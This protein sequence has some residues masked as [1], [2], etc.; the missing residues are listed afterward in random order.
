MEF[1][2]L[3]DLLCVFVTSCLLVTLAALIESHPDTRDT[4]NQ[5]ISQCIGHA[6]IRG[7]TPRCRIRDRNHSV[8][9]PHIAADTVV[10]VRDRSLSHTT[11]DDGHTQAGNAVV[12]DSVLR[13]Q[14]MGGCIRHRPSKAQERD[15]GPV[16]QTTPLQPNITT[17]THSGSHLFTGLCISVWST[18][19]TLHSTTN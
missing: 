6:H 17:Q 12:P 14:R 9:I 18:Y 15:K 11:H 13:A 19:N 3:S 16:G 2:E 1:D 10:M 8:P 5:E 7:R 4:C